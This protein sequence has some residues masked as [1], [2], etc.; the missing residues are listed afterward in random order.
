MNL[1]I[2][3]ILNETE[4]IMSEIRSK[5]YPSQHKNIKKKLFGAAKQD[6][7]YEVQMSGNDILKKEFLKQ[8]VDKASNSIEYFSLGLKASLG[9]KQD[10]MKVLSQSKRDDLFESN[11]IQAVID[12]KWEAYTKN[13]FL[14]QFLYFLLFVVFFAVNILIQSYIQDQT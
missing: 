3:E 12:F 13:Y 10:F 5:T 11:S 1:D 9:S 14:W 2:K 4:I 8:K 6:S 7:I